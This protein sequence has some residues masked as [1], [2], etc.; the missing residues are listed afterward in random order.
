MSERA[1]RIE[2]VEPKFKV[3]LR[4]SMLDG[5]RATEEELRELYEDLKELFEEERGEH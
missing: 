2:V 4:F 5:I 1:P 3:R